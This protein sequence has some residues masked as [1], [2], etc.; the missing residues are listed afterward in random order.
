MEVY[1]FVEMS[2]KVAESQ[3]A[4]R[5]GNSVVTLVMV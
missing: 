3:G 5:M 4:G 2:R 1:Y